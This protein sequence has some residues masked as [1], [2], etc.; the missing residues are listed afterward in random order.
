MLKIDKNFK[1][2]RF[3]QLKVGE[4]FRV[5]IE[6]KDNYNWYLVLCKYKNHTKI[7]ELESKEIFWL[8]KQD[9]VMLDVEIPNESF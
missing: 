5:Y 4:L 8:S 7:Y 2:I 3:L 9:L 1:T 6:Y